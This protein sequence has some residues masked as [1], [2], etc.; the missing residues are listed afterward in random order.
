MKLFLFYL[1]SFLIKLLFLIFF[2]LQLKF[3]LYNQK[4]DYFDYFFIFKNYN[5]E[6]YILKINLFNDIKELNIYN[7]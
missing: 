7:Y 4:F 2:N 3:F 1:Y 6:Q 5:C